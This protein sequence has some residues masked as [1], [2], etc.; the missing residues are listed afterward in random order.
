M[1]SSKV[2]DAELSDKG[3]K[4]ANNAKLKVKELLTS[5]NYLF[6]SDLKRTRQTMYNILGSIEPGKRPN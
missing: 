6:I 5:I 2:T 3:I 1:L 4:Q